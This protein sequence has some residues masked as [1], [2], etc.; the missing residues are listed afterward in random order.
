MLPG[1]LR[2]YRRE[3]LA[4]D[5]VAGAVVAVMLVP[6]SMAYA[7]LAGLPPVTGLYASMLPLVAYAALG[8]SMTLAV[9]PAALDSLMVAAALAGVAAGGDPLAAAR[10]ALL[11]G[12][13][14]TLVGVL[15]FGVLA[16][17]LS[18]PVVSGFTSAAAL[19]IACSQ[20]AALLALEVPRDHDFASQLLASLQALPDAGA[21]TAALGIGALGLL[22][23]ARLLAARD[24]PGRL[25]LMLAR[26][27]PLL[28]VLAGAA[29]VWGYDLDR[30]AGVA[31][32]GVIPSAVPR[33]AVPTGKLHAWLDLLPSAALIALVCSLESLSVGRTLASRRREKIT[34]NRELVALGAA[35]FAAAVSGGYNVAG[36]LGRSLVNYSAGARTPLASVVTAVLV[37]T[38]ALLL[39]P[40]FAYLPKTVLA[41]IV[42]AAVVPLVDVASFARTWRY[43]PADALS[44]G[45]TFVTVLA[46]GIE[47]GIIVGV[48]LSLV[49]HLWRTSRPHIAIVGRVGD[50]E[51]FRNVQRHAV[52]TVPEVLA[53]RIDE[54]LYFA[55]AHALEDRVL[56]EIAERP[57]VRH[58]VLVASAV[59]FIDASALETL[60][61]LV[62]RLRDAGVTFH[63]AEI[64]GPVMDRLQHSDFL[65]RLQPGQVFLSTH[66]AMRAL[67][68]G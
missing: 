46:A 21:V 56:A 64:K 2:H 20:L 61:A 16:N 23:G 6:Q 33:L 62:N 49:L 8:T 45:A 11:T 31:V 42:I 44:L 68:D 29:L 32:T 58:V 13:I 25:R 53:V 65:A 63:L 19:V 18:V 40:L 47:R 60:D 55:S 41:A 1:W 24:R 5:L 66:A 22:A 9:G 27:G 34:A 35:N 39:G 59:N 3:A 43:N 28:V 30:T 54:S 17:F 12:A 67:G 37:L 7:L 50:T 36:G 48:A 38:F 10:L 14:L 15:R 26:A 57:Q 4:P 51:H 52:R